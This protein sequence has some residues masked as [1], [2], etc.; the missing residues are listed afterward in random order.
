VSTLFGDIRLKRRLYRDEDNHYRFLLD[1]QMRLDKGSHM[2]SKMR[3]LAVLASTH[4][5]FREVRQD[6]KAIFP[7][8]ASHT[9]IDNLSSKVADCYIAE[10]KKEVSAIFEDGVITETKG[11]VVPHLVIEA[12]G[13]SVALQREEER[14]AEIKVGIAHEG[15][16]EISK[17]PYKLKEKSVCSGIMKG[18]RFW[19]GF[20]LNLAKKYHLSQID[21]VIVGG[22]GASWWSL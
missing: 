17:G 3:E 6:I 13:V 1:E 15:W 9:T 5:T 14:R 4:H 18:D 19:E 16:Q 20:S 11:R 7:W 22:D 10:E 2:S 21:K 12:D 8:G